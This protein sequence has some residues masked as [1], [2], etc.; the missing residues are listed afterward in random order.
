MTKQK[1]TV[2]YHIGRQLV[3]REVLHIFMFCVDYFSQLAPIHHLFEH[4]HFYSV[5]EF[6]ICGSI[7][8]HYLGDGRPPEMFIF[9][10]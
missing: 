1:S 2:P 3:P 9:T 4:P 8:T 5:V 7:G 10:G 6:G